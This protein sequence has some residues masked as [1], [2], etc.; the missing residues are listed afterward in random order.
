[1][2]DDSFVSGDGGDEQM[3]DEYDLRDLFARIF[4]NEF[5][6]DESERRVWGDAESVSASSPGRLRFRPNAAVPLFDVVF[7]SIKYHVRREHMYYCAGTF[8]VSEPV[9]QHCTFDAPCETCRDQLH[10]RAP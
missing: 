4:V 8:N 1:M 10:A 2:E 6:G 9:F 7:H 3:V 5:G